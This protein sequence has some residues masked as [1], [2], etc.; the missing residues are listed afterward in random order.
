LSP[1]PFPAFVKE[2]RC[3]AAP[4]LL[5]RGPHRGAARKTKPRPAVDRCRARRGRLASRLTEGNAEP[6][7]A[8][9]V[10]DFV[11]KDWCASCTR[12]GG[13]LY[14]FVSR[15]R[16][17]WL[18]TDPGL[19]LGAPEIIDAP[20]LGVSWSS[21]LV[22]SSVFW[23]NGGG[24][25]GRNPT[26]ENGAF[27]R[28]SCSE[29]DL[30]DSGARQRPPSPIAVVDGRPS[31]LKRHGYGTLVTCFAAPPGGAMLARIRASDFEVQQ[32]KASE[33]NR[34]HRQGERARAGG[35]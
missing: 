33:R 5:G 30:S 31:D 7:A 13:R 16:F 35:A 15:A 3:W 18:A 22:L 1:R 8:L 32:R 26:E 2:D 34:H 23:R 10:I 25:D 9:A 19:M 28:R 12:A 27:T 14:R 6:A 11:G 21:F 4:T 20:G 29:I 17:F 24:N